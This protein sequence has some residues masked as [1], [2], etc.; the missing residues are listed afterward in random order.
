MSKPNFVTPTTIPSVQGYKKKNAE[1]EK[2]IFV[3]LK[4]FF[5]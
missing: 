2:D 5:K 3:S 1:G 4:N